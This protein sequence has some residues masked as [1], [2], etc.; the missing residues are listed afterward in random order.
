MAQLVENPPA[1][2]EIVG[3]AGDAG[4]TPG[5]GRSLGEG[6]GNPLLEFFP[7]KSYGWRKLVGYSP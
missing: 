7:G 4:S 5:S 1:M 3:N 6:N 2:Q